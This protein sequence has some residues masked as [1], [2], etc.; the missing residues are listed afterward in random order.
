MEQY[1]KWEAVNKPYEGDDDIVILERVEV[2]KDMTEPNGPK[3][4]QK[5]LKVTWM[6]LSDC[7]VFHLQNGK[8]RIVQYDGK[9]T[10]Q[11]MGEHERA[12][13]ITAE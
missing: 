11:W 2:L 3:K 8:C 1:L 12:P 13:V 10:P 7:V 4:G 6:K 9:T 5:Y